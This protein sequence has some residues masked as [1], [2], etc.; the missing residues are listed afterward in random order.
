MFLR[1]PNMKKE[2]IVLLLLSVA[3]G[4]LNAQMQKGAM[5]FGIGGKYYQSK[6]EL[7]NYNTQAV[8]PTKSINR[9]IEAQVRFG[10][11]LADRFVL[12]GV[13]GYNNT[14]QF[15]QTNLPYGGTTWED[16]KIETFS[17]G[18]FGRL[19]KMFGER[20]VGVF[21][22]FGGNYFFGHNL[23]STGTNYNYSELSKDVKGFNAA[24]VPGIVLFLTKRIGVEATFGYFGFL[25]LTESNVSVGKKTANTTDIWDLNYGLAATMI[26]INFYI[27]ADKTSAQQS[28]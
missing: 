6:G 3:T 15:V 18:F 16:H 28:Q 1:N 11:F 20:R 17:Y 24:I 14:L 10:Y 23:A 19:Y 26:G 22:Q 4:F 7:T 27:G 9:Q 21:G 2:Y 8:V 25:R 12:G 13:V 5:I